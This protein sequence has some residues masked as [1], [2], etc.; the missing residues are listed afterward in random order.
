M[1]GR[2]LGDPENPPHWQPTPT[3]HVVVELDE[4]EATAGWKPGFYRVADMTPH[5]VINKHQ[6][7]R[8]N[9]IARQTAELDLADIRSRSMDPEMQAILNHRR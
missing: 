8:L 9:A 6:L 1:A 3:R 4:A 5:Q 7:A 2:F